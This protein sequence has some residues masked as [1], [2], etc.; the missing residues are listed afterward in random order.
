[1]ISRSGVNRGY[2]GRPTP[3]IDLERF[4]NDLREGGVEEMFEMLLDTFARDCP[5]RFAA[6][7]RAVESQDPGAIQSAAHAF[8]SGAI[9]IRAEMLGGAL[10][11]MEEAA[12]SGKLESVP[13]LFEEIRVQKTGVLSTLAGMAL[14]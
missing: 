3:F 1:M 13:D 6:L 14:K 4:R 9:T 11:Q 10:S 8:K 2:G 5:V 12:R 7:E